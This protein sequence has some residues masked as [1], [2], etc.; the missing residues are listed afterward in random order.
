MTRAE[1][2][3]KVILI[4]CRRFV[5]LFLF[6]FSFQSPCLPKWPKS[7][8]HYRP[9]PLIARLFTLNLPGRGTSL[10]SIIFDSD[11]QA[12]FFYLLSLSFVFICLTLSKCSICECAYTFLFISSSFSLF[13]YYFALP[14][15]SSS[16]S[17]P[18]AYFSAYR[19]ARKFSSKRTLYA[20]GNAFKENLLSRMV[21]ERR[22]ER[23]A[24]LII[25]VRANSGNCCDYQDFVLVMVINGQ[26]N[27]I[28]RCSCACVCFG[29]NK[30]EICYCCPKLSI[31]KIHSELKQTD[32]L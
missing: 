15:P 19:R 11:G 16:P 20:H 32:A 21:V 22:K 25:T 31:S 12:H 13:F 24:I 14:F 17:S 30:N 18:S 3:E 29:H 10:C 4:I 26:T 6:S 23:G 2:R 5:F 9:C 27:T 1:D 8:R 28:F 7:R